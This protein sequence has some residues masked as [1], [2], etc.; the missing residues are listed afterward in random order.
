MALK[1]AL[2]TLNNAVKDLTSLHV[3]TYSGT[4]SFKD[5][6][7][8][9]TFDNLRD[10]LSKGKGPDDSAVD[11]Q[12]KLET[13]VKFDGDSYN[14][15]AKENVSDE[16]FKLHKDAIDSGLK[17]RLGLMEMMKNLFD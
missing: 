14:F 16:L 7:D 13:L 2:Q 15:V 9:E 1:E 11:V 10:K 12:L 5:R 8:N 6:G 4:V 3:Q 17:T